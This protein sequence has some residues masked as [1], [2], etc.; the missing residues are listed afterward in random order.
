MAVRK[1]LTQLYIS[2]ISQKIAESKKSKE[3]MNGPALNLEKERSKVLSSHDT[4]NVLKQSFMFP[5]EHEVWWV[6]AVAFPV[7]PVPLRLRF[8]TVMQLANVK[9]M[10]GKGLLCFAS[11]LEWFSAFSNVLCVRFAFGDRWVEQ[12]P[13]DFSHNFSGR[14]MAPLCPLPVM[15]QYH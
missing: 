13:Q 15:V 3:T 2:S 8:A 12:E 9:P 6:K 1:V 7:N 10:V 5:K 14:L 4:D 11:R